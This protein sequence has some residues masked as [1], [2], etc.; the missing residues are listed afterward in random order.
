V[1][2]NGLDCRRGGCSKVAK[3]DFERLEGVGGCG[4]GYENIPE[5]ADKALESAE[6]RKTLE[7]FCNSLIAAL[8][9]RPH[10]SSYGLAECDAHPHN[11][12]PRKSSQ[13]SLRPDPIS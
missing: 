9:D 12:C 6:G 11:H 4:T 2:E 10:S 5:V 8:P 13:K 3:D 1:D 7:E